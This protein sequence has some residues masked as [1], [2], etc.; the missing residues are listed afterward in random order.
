MYFITKGSVILFDQRG[1]TPF[2]QLPQ[3]SFFGEYQMMFDLRANYSV[4]VGGKEQLGNHA[5]NAY[6]KHRFLCV[7]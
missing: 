6:E 4:K 1:I 2:L 7:D 3:Y 5:S